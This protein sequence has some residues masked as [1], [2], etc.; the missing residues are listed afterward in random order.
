MAQYASADNRSLPHVMPIMTA[1]R[2]LGS[3]LSGTPTEVVFPVMPVAV[4]TPA[5]P[6]LVAAPA[7]ATDGQWVLIEEVVWQFHNPHQQCLGFVLAGAKTSLR[8]KAMPWLSK[9]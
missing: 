9:P 4:K 2:A 3:T 7:P 6:L 1:A 8:A 5:L